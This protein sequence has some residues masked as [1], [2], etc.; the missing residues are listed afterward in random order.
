MTAGFHADLLAAFKSST[1]RSNQKVVDS[2][3][4][5]VDAGNQGDDGSDIDAASIMTPATTS[6]RPAIINDRLPAINMIDRPEDLCRRPPYHLIVRS[7]DRKVVVQGSHQPS[8]ELLAEYLKKWSKINHNFVNKVCGTELQM[9]TADNEYSLLQLRSLCKAPHSVW[10]LC[11]TEW[12]SSRNMQTGIPNSTQQLCYALLR[13]SWATMS[14]FKMRNVGTTG[15]IVPCNRHILIT[16]NAF[17]S[18]SNVKTV[19]FQPTFQRSEQSVLN[20]WSIASIANQQV[21]SISSAPQ[22]TLRCWG[23]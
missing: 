5:W 21:R 6:I 10:V 12:K 15:E 2:S 1:D 18:D 20:L 17:T 9:D 8:L 19:S 3:S 22:V 16:R 23:L 7:T 14:L 11:M 4:G 13:V